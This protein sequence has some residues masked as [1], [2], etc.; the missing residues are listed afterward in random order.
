MIGGEASDEAISGD[1]ATVRLIANLDKAHDVCF[2]FSGSSYGSI[3]GLAF[4][5][6]KCKITV[7][8]AR[9]SNSNPYQTGEV[10]GSDLVYE[11]CNFARGP[12][13]AF[14]NHMGEVITWRDCKFHGGGGSPGLLNTWR[15]DQKP[16]NCSSNSRNLT[17]GITLTEFRMF[18]GEFTGDN[19][20]NI[21][22]GSILFRYSLFNLKRIK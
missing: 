14:A 4:E 9:T 12:V 22:L 1:H 21:I 2:D 15:L 3:K 5:G 17:T 6:A 20:A 8:N 18:G 10:Y 7:L 13:A 16:Y 11:Q 19:S